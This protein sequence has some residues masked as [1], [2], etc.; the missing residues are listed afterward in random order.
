MMAP[1]L[2]VSMS[3]STPVLDQRLHR[4][5]W[6]RHRADEPP[7]VVAALG[8]DTPALHI[9]AA[10]GDTSKQASSR[11]AAIHTHEPLDEGEALCLQHA[12]DL[13][14]CP[15]EGDLRVAFCASLRV[16]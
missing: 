6:R 14:E 10:L 13:F 8:P 2:L 9:R 4:M 1:S 5:W 7:M 15:G 11:A 3:A 12:G 16:R